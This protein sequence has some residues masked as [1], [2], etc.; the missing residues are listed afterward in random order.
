MKCIRIVQALAKNGL[1]KDKVPV[2][3]NYQG[4]SASH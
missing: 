1:V 3:I 2:F 4:D